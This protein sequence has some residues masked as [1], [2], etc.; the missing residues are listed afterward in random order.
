MN[1]TIDFPFKGGNKKCI[2]FYGSTAFWCRNLNIYLHKALY[3]GQCNTLLKVVFLEVGSLTVLKT[4]G[5]PRG[6]DPVPL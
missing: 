5:I 3:T 1:N 6:I 4:I 2:D